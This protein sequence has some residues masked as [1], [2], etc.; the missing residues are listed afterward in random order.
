MDDKFGSEVPPE[1]KQRL[2]RNCLEEL[3]DTSSFD[4][5]ELELFDWFSKEVEAV[6]DRII[7][8]EREY[9]EEQVEAGI[10]EINDTGIVAA[11]YYLKRS[12]YSHV[13]YLTSLFEVFLEQ[14]CSRLTLALGDHAI[15]FALNELNGKEWQK[16][17]KYLERYGA[18]ETPEALWEPV[19]HLMEVRNLIVHRNGRT[20]D[21]G[22]KQRA[23][24]MGPQGVDLGSPYVMV[25]SDY[26]SDSFDAVKRLCAD[27]EQGVSQAIGRVIKPVSLSE[28]K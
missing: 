2:R 15:P 18:F 13:I 19:D 4:V 9:V 12:R 16:R 8:A 14:E 20:S 24:L 22:R 6:I 5:Y 25:Q 28:K 17:R 3:R 10:D 7:S 11:E 1:V 27:I 23:R 21:L 26:I